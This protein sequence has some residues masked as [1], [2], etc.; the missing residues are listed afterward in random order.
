MTRQDAC[1]KII[2]YLKKDKEHYT[3]EKVVEDSYDEGDLQCSQIYLEPMNPTI[4]GWLREDL[5]T[6]FPLDGEDVV[7]TLE[8][9]REYTSL[10]ARII[11]IYDADVYYVDDGDSTLREG[12]AGA[13]A[14]CTSDAGGASSVG[15]MAPEHMTACVV[16]GMNPKKKNK[17][18]EK[19]SETRKRLEERKRLNERLSE[20]V[21]EDKVDE[22]LKSFKKRELP[23]RVL[24]NGSEDYEKLRKSWLEGKDAKKRYEKTLPLIDD[25]NPS[26]NPIGEVNMDDRYTDG[27][28]DQFLSW[29]ESHEKKVDPVKT[30]GDYGRPRRKRDSIEARRAGRLQE[31]RIDKTRVEPL[32]L[33]RVEKY[34][35]GFPGI[36]NYEMNSRY[37]DVEFEDRRIEVNFYNGLKQYC[38]EISMVNIVDQNGY[39]FKWQGASTE[40]F[41]I[42]FENAVNLDIEL[43]MKD[44]LKERRVWSKSSH[45]NILQRVQQWIEKAADGKVTVGYHES[46]NGNRLEAKFPGSTLAIHVYNLLGTVDNTYSIDI[47]DTSSGEDEVKFEGSK[48]DLGEMK[49]DVDEAVDYCLKN[50]GG[51]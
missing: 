45:G 12:D 43:E 5:N 21:K 19:L 44:N 35:R 20:A 15:A 49:N 4:I 38:Y 14:V 3:I 27:Q 41:E 28:V 1:K 7:V 2:T 32:N 48:S 9:N 10:Y 31:R 34:V 13:G 6:M 29:Y 30:V 51:K 33:G 36:K 8:N 26:H 17:K 50:S 39:K 18:D 25:G 24:Y 11:N 40:E 22:Y 16:T 47:V 23:K 46:L 37:L 42:D